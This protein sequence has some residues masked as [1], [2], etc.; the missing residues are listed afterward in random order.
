MRAGAWRGRPAA[1]FLLHATACGRACTVHDPSLPDSDSDSV[2]SIGAVAGGAG[3]WAVAQFGYTELSRPAPAVSGPP[4]CIRRNLST[5]APAL[6]QRQPVRGLSNRK[7]ASLLRCAPRA[8][9][10]PRH[11]RMRAG[12]RP[13]A[14][15]PFGGGGDTG[16]PPPAPPAAHSGNAPPPSPAGSSNAAAPT[17]SSS[18]VPQPFAPP[19]PPP[20]ISMQASRACELV[21]GL[22]PGHAASA[23]VFVVQGPVSQPP[24]AYA[25]MDW[26][27][28]AFRCGLTCS[29]LPV[30]T[31]SSAGVLL[32]LTAPCY[33]RACA[34]HG[35]AHIVSA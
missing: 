1:S 7:M 26:M 2:T 33:R 5:A 15:F 35:A 34:C 22:A 23:R 9:A 12:R 18:A 17:P 10:P 19:P 24:K 8:P 14:L 28:D 21:W 3:G 27:N 6:V 4:L 20:I 29:E 16:A 13:A 11:G 25:M 32:A 31:Q 30:C